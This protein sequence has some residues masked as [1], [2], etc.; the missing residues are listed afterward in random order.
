MAKKKA[1]SKAGRKSAKLSQA[2]KTA[3]AGS[4]GG[5]SPRNAVKKKSVATKKVVAM[6]KAFT[7]DVVSINPT[8]SPTPKD[9]E[10]AFLGCHKV[11]VT[12]SIG[13]WLG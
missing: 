3:S 2:K 10:N 7:T 11:D 13:T 8:S 6:K 9:L 12:I 5:K 4:A 1:V